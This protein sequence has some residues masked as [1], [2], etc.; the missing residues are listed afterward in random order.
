MRR[1][2]LNLLVLL[3]TV[4]LWAQQSSVNKT[5]KAAIQR[6]KS[7]IVSSFDRSLPNVNL[8][9]F[10]KYEGAGAPIKW[11]VSDCGDQTGSPPLDQ[12]HG[13]PMCVEAHF[14]LKGQTAVAVLVSVGTLKGGPSAVPALISVAITESG[15]SRSVRHLS[16][17]PMELHRPPPRLPR[18]LPVPVGAL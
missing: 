5:E 17:L 16:D 11:E 4:S 3:L 2:I 12:E 15:T 18:D 9:F 14:E 6:A 13:P 1:M 7:L 10:L 8:E